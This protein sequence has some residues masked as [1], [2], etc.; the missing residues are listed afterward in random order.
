MQKGQVDSGEPGENAA[1][2]VVSANT[3]TPPGCLTA[4]V[5]GLLRFCDVELPCCTDDM[6]SIFTLPFSLH[7]NSV[8]ISKSK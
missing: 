7:S 1:V 5:L 6:R 3:T 8:V 2:L 4:I